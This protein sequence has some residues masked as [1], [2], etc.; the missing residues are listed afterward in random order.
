MNY[1]ELK[2]ELKAKD[3]WQD[4][5]IAQLAEIGFDSFVETETGFL[6]Y[7]VESEFD[8]DKT[9]DVMHHEVVQSYQTNSIA[10]QNWNAEWE[11]NFD[12]VYVEKKVAIIA[13]FHETPSGF[14]L[15]VNIMP[16]MSFGTGH[17]Q[18]T[19]LMSRA[20]FEL[21]VKDKLVLDM[22]TGT[23]ILAII[24]EKRGAAKIFAPDIDQWSFEN[25]QENC[26]TNHCKNIEVVLGGAEQI[27]GKNFHIILANINKNVLIRQFSVYSTALNDNG[28]L[29]ISGFF[30]TDSD[31]LVQEAAQ[32][33]FIF[34][35]MDTREGWALIHLRK[36][37]NFDKP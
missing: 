1:L 22:G 30:E 5:F 26:E 14:E 9:K 28:I 23:G 32:H 18:T 19:W 35:H 6:A 25:A 13:P 17:H 3:P 24:A 12:P 16:K 29:L 4:I 27:T 33:G 36:L 2:A 7:I 21:D 31:Q 15:V 11:K 20:I 37:T 8:S 10:D 34:E